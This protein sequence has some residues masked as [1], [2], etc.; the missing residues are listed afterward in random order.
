[1]NIAKRA[2][3]MAAGMGS[4]MRPATLEMPKPLISVNGVP[5]IDSIIAA[6]H[7]NGINEI[8]IVAGYM[9]EKFDYLKEKHLGIEVLENPYF[10][11]CN[12]ISSLYIAR[13][14]INDAIILDGDQVIYNREILNPR[15]EKSCYCAAFVEKTPEWL[16]T[17]EDG[18][19]VSCSRTGGQ[20]GY[21]L[22]GVSFWSKED[23][24]RLKGHLEQEFI[25]NRNTE[26]YWDD[27]AMFC[28]PDEYR[29]GIREINSGDLIEI[30]SLEEL[31]AVDPSYLDLYSKFGSCV[32]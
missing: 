21:R 5:M 16:L 18:E 1:M 7:H 4:R 10:D 29:L 8:Y 14:Y 25:D 2:I 23:G 13:D 22:C 19:I 11:S 24:R 31:A 30:D 9:K 28:H 12:N 27:I 6:L 20:N 3:I 26:L 15:F 32:F 17:V